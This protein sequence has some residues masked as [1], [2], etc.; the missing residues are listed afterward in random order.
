MD[1]MTSL[2]GLIGSKLMPWLIGAGAVLAALFGARLSGKRS[3]KKDAEIDALK[4]RIEVED[5]IE[6]SHAGGAAWSD[7]LRKL[8]D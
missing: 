2:L 5:A 6:K 3:A 8:D 7:R 4:K 1:M